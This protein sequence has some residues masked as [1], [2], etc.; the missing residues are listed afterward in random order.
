MAPQTMGGGGEQSELRVGV[1]YHLKKGIH[2]GDIVIPIAHLAI[3]SI[4]LSS[5]HFLHNPHVDSITPHF[6][7]ATPWKNHMFTTQLSKC[8]QGCCGAH[9]PSASNGIV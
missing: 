7:C 8:R 1:L 4:L 6:V 2:G 5:G 3:P 9:Y